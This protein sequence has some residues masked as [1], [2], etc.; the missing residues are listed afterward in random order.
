MASQINARFAAFAFSS[1]G[2]RRSRSMACRWAASSISSSR[3]FRSASA[4]ATRWL[5]LATCS[6]T[7]DIRAS[8]ALSRWWSTCLRSPLAGRMSRF[9]ALRTYSQCTRPCRA[10]PSRPAHGR[11]QRACACRIHPGCRGNSRRGISCACFLMD[12]ER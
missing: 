3:L 5:C 8:A 2:W 10:C 1:V 7:T 9:N 6:R 4:L 11:D 12:V